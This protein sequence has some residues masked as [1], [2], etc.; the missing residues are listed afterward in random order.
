MI[1]CFID[2]YLQLSSDPLS[3]TSSDTYLEILRSEYFHGLQTEYK[4]VSSRYLLFLFCILHGV[5]AGETWRNSPIMPYLLEIGRCA[6]DTV[7]QDLRK[8]KECVEERFAQCELFCREKLD[9]DLRCK[10]DCMANMSYGLF[11]CKMNRRSW[12]KR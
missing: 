10:P 12:L 7:G 4:M 2:K 9:N 11:S 1:G 3:L 6:D 8:C 5:T